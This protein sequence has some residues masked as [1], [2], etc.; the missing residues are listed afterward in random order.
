M[1]YLNSVSQFSDLGFTLGD[2]S[3]N[4]DIGAGIGAGIGLAFDLIGANQQKVAIEKRFRAF[5]QTAIQNQTIRRNQLQTRRLQERL[6]AAQAIEDLELSGQAALASTYQSALES[7]IS[8]NSVKALNNAQRMQLDRVRR[9]LLDRQ[10]QLDDEFLRQ[11]RAIIRQT[12][13]SM[14][15][16]AF[17]LTNQLPSIYEVIGSGIQA[18][19]NVG[20]NFGFGDISVDETYPVPEGY[21]GPT[22]D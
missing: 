16:S 17:S 8:G 1:A 22:L 9:R 13:Q 10:V 2:E 19:I 12:R 14:I 7:G 3:G 21:A 18:G 5:S 6:N 11:D 20:Q 4:S 15:D